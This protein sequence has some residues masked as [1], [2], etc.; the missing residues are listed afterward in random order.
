MTLVLGGTWHYACYAS[1][2]LR[3]RCNTE[4]C[5]NGQNH[6]DYPRN[7]TLCRNTCATLANMQHRC[8]AGC[9]ADDKQAALRSLRLLRERMGNAIKNINTGDFRECATSSKHRLLCYV[10]DRPGAGGNG[11]HRSA[12]RRP[13]GGLS[14]QDLGR[15]G[16]AG[17]PTL[18]FYGVCLLGS[19]HICLFKSCSRLLIASR[20]FAFCLLLLIA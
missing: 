2:T 6:I 18:T 9:C 20:G 16:P 13:C 5:A 4:C 3:Q 19:A 10:H 17:E 11:V 15:I 14:D 7:P 12:R 8:N 1:D